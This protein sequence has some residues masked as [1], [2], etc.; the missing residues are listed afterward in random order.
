LPH[1]VPY[2]TKLA[3]PV[4]TTNYFGQI[5]I[6]LLQTSQSHFN[7]APHPLFHKFV[8]HQGPINLKNSFPSETI[9]GFIIIL[10]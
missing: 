3:N 5:A 9:A 6:L 10:A 2:L 7:L 4:E 8:S 1:D